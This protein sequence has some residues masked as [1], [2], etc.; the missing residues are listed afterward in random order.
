ML[1]FCEAC[2][3]DSVVGFVPQP[4][5]DRDFLFFMFRCMKQ[6]LLTDAPVNTQGNLNVERIGIKAIPF[7]SIEEQQ[8]IVKNIEAET[9]TFDMAMARTERE[10]ALMQEYRTRLTADVVTGKLDVRIVAARLPALPVDAIPATDLL[11]E[12]EAQ[13]IP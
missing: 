7:P 8:A 2:F 13:E 10:I 6:E 4:T 12:T 3:P 5:L 1:L 9:G 11:E